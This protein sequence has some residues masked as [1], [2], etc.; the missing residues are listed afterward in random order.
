MRPTN[1]REPMPVWVRPARFAL[2]LTAAGG[3][4]W[5]VAGGYGFVVIALLVVA[6]A[7]WLAG[8]R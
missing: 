7:W 2:L 4:L 5:L 6:V 1:A 8:R 3:A